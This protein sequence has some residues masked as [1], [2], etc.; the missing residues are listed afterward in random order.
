V[1]MQLWYSHERFLVRKTLINL[2]WALVVSYLKSREVNSQEGCSGSPTPKI[3]YYGWNTFELLL[4]YVS[5]REAIM[6]IYIKIYLFL[7]CSLL[8]TTNMVFAE[9]IT[10]PKP[11]FPPFAFLLDETGM[12]DKGIDQLSIH[13][14]I[15]KLPSE[16][17]HYFEQANYKRIVNDIVDKQPKIIAGLFKNQKRIDRG[18]LYSKIPMHL[19]LPNQLVILKT[20]YHHFLEFIEF[21]KID[22]E[23]LVLSKKQ[24]V[25]VSHGRAYSGIIDIILD[26]HRDKIYTRST[27]DENGLLQMLEKERIDATLEFPISAGYSAHKLNMK[28]KIL[29]IP[30][31][32]MEEYTEAYVAGPSN[33]WGKYKLKAIDRIMQ[34][35][36]TIKQFALFYSNW[37]PNA[38]SKSYYHELLKKYYDKEHDIQVEF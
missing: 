17:N 38:V 1:L 4:T 10:W 36:E 26:R 34:K 23:K 14:L 33:T 2:I 30:I 25:G 12:K 21:D 22:F 16:W 18:V 32:G 29:L 13:Y 31:L 28:D 35:P 20:N 9:E 3:G 11:D 5:V 37:L 19:A 6:Y 24:V 27:S 8:F 7:L 15:K